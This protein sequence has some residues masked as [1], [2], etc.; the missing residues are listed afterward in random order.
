MSTPVSWA[1]TNQSGLGGSQSEEFGGGDSRYGIFQ[2]GVKAVY[3]SAKKNVRCRF[4]PARDLSLSVNDAAFAG[5]VVPYRDRA[6]GRIDEDT[7]S[8]AFTAWYT[9]IVEYTMIGNSRTSFLSPITLQRLG[10]QNADV[11]D[12]L[13]IIRKYA[14]DNVRWASLLEAK[15]GQ[16]KT[17]SELLPKLKFSALTNTLAF[18]DRNGQPDVALMKLSFTAFKNFKEKLTAPRPAAQPALSNDEWAQM[19]MLG[20]VTHPLYGLLAIMQ[21][22]TVGTIQTCTPH[23]SQSPY[24]LQGHQQYPIDPNTPFGKDVLEKRYNFFSDKVL[25]VLPF[26]DLVEWVVGDGAIPY[27]L[28]QEALGNICAIPPRPANAPSAISQPGAS[29]TGGFAPAPG[30]F[31]PPTGGFAQP[32]QNGFTAP[33]LPAMSAAAGGFAPPS[34][35]AAPPMSFAP[36]PSSYGTQPVE[37]TPAQTMWTPPPPAPVTP[38]PPPAPVTPPPPPVVVEPKFWVSNN[39]GVT[40]LTKSGVLDLMK[41]GWNGP[42]MAENQVGGWKT[43]ADFGL[44]IQAAPTPPPAPTAPVAPTPPPP[45]AAPSFQQ[46]FPAQGPATPP[47]S[48][49]VPAA[50]NAS[51]LTPEKQARLDSYIAAISSGQTL[52]PD[53]LA[54]YANMVRE[55]QG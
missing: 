20:D 28:V 29:P 22:T 26:Q 36:P 52:Q 12:P 16:G 10:V 33:P 53:Q 23:F 55:S 6:S 8:P 39:G 51:K 38:P 25:K 50:G 54:D 41:Q 42:V 35:F 34:D 40:G 19:F 1:V 44:S 5:S 2:Q 31:A 45:P 3:A 46:G 7:K 18:D 24:A 13:N 32:A 43:A 14:K 48:T 21:Q 4:L 9:M 30:G 27:E 37:A 49:A 47:A 11:R 15:L 17:A